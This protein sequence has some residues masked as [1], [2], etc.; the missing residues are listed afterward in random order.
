MKCSSVV[1]DFFGWL[2]GLLPVGK[3]LLNLLFCRLNGPSAL[4]LSSHERG[5]SPL[6]V[7]LS[8][9]WTCSRKS[10]FFFH[11]GDQNWTQYPRCGLARAERRG[12]ITSIDL[13]VAL[14]PVQFRRLLPP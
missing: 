2:V 14:V 9:C 12:R 5:S 4:G 8:L 7:F 3:I 1:L 10:V 11:W 13:L 6:T